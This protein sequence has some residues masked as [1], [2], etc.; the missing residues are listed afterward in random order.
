MKVTQILNSQPIKPP[1]YKRIR[2]AFVRGHNRL[3]ELT[4]DVFERVARQHKYI[5]YGG[6]RMREIDLPSYA[7]E[8]DGYTYPDVVI[9][10]IVLYEEDL[11][12]MKDMSYN[13]FIEY[14]GKLLE[15]GRYKEEDY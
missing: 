2:T 3:K 12:K 13:E 10:K 15:Q 6:V 14:R 7:G 4:Q 9:K 11:A 5:T 1:L 8:P